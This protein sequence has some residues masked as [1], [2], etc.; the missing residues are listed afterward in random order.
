MKKYPDA[1]ITGNTNPPRSG[2]FEILIN[3][4]L[5]YSKFELNRFPTK[6]EISE[7]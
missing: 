6:D 2:S 7:W 1:K 3:N 5:I 4:E